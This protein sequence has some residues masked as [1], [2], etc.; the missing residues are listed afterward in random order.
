MTY[1]KQ[2]RAHPTA[3]K[4]LAD[5]PDNGKQGIAE[6]MD[7]LRRGE[8]LLPREKRSYGNGIFALKY[9]EGHNEF[10]CYYAHQ[11]R[12]GQVLLA[13]QYIYKKDQKAK[14]KIPRDR[15]AEWEAEHRRRSR[16][17]RRKSGI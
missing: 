11:G 9:S 6:L 12:F 10:R 17:D 5:L 13:L 7:R 4:E 1:K 8:T 15:L 14:L 3:K 2:W 16:G